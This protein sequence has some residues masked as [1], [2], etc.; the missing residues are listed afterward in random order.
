MRTDLAVSAL[1]RR[2]EGAAGIA[3]EVGVV[4]GGAQM[5]SR[6]LAEGRYNPLSLHS[7]LVGCN[8]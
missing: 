8:R 6:V 3:S 5:G 1:S 4:R 7:D 2:Q